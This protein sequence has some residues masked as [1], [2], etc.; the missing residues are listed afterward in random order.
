MKIVVTGAS[1][2]IGSALV[3]RLIKQHSLTLLSRSARREQN[4]ANKEW[5]VWQ[6]GQGGAWE[7]AVDG[8]DGVINLAGEPIAGKR[9]SAAQKQE[10]RG[11]RINGTRALI[12]TIAKAKVKPRFL[13]SASAVGYYGP[14]GDEIISEDTAPGGDFLANL[15]VEWEALARQAEACGVRVALLRTGIVLGKGS[16]ALARM[17]PPFKMFAGGPLGSGQ[18]WMPWIHIDDQVGLISYLMANEQARGAFNLTAPNP[19]TMEDFAK[20]LGA[21]LNRPAWA[22]VPGFAL[23]FMLGEMA[24]MLLHGQRAVPKAALQL[25]YRFKYPKIAEALGALH[26]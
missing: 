12:Q 26:L 4:S 3:D 20:A 13:L 9:W 8:A 24:D 11:S 21:A 15:C 7:Q 23:S 1:G 18:Q 19:V 5:A 17:V 6:P 10:L 14:H 22:R 25:G 2:F 16:G